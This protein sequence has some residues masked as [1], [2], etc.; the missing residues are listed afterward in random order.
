MRTIKMMILVTSTLLASAT[1]ATAEE[2]PVMNPQTGFAVSSN[3]L[4]PPA[5]LAPQFDAPALH[6][7]PMA[8][9]TSQAY[10]PAPQPA[11]AKPE[12]VKQSDLMYL[13]FGGI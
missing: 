11:A 12:P 4:R 6:A 3:D 10:R 7:H 9:H 8:N 13:N 1:M 5:Y 2:Y